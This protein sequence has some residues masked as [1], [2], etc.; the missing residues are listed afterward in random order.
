MKR[1]TLLKSGV[2]AFAAA[3]VPLRRVALESIAASAP[4]ASEFTDGQITTLKAIAAVVLPSEIGR[5]GIDEATDRF[6][7]WVR[8]YRP[9]ADLD[10]GYGFTRIRTAPPSPLPG[11]AAQLQAL[12]ALAGNGP[13]FAALPAARQRELV[14]Q[15]LEGIDR[16]PLRPDGK[17]LVADFMGFYLHSGE[18]NDLCYQAEIGREKCRGLQDSNRAPRKRTQP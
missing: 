15:A 4:G 5:T 10:H 16:L 13:G 14:T 11:Y 6:A 17:N 12:D 8:N 2:T 18:A 1:R 7:R 9:D 3:A